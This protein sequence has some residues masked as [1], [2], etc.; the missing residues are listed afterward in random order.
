MK[1][2][3]DDKVLIIKGKDRGKS[4][5]VLRVVPETGKIAIEGLNL[6]KKRSRPKKAGEKGQILNFPTLM[7]ADN[8]MFIC[9]QCSAPVRVGYKIENKKKFRICQKC[10]Q[11]I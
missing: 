6:I 8:V 4:G 2:K 9:S 11:G 1:I 10:K 5:T 3:K 7:F